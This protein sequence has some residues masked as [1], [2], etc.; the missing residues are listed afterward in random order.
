MFYHAHSP[1]LSSLQCMTGSS[2]FCSSFFINLSDNSI[3]SGFVTSKR[4]QGSRSRYVFNSSAA[5]KRD[6]WSVMG[7]LSAL[8]I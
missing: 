8:H 2:F 1:N 3:K 4:I 6:S 5:K 7:G